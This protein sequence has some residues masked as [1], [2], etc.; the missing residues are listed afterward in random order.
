MELWFNQIETQFALHQIDDDDERYNLTCAALSGEIA[1]DVRDVL[2]QPFRSNKYDS[3]KA[4]LIERR[5]LTTPERVNKVISGEKIGS[6]IPSRFLRRLQKTAG[7]GTKAVVGKAVI[8]QAFIRQMPASIRAHLATQP[9]SA[10]LESLAILADRALAAEEDVEESKPGVAE[11]KVDETS[12]LVGLLEDLSKRIKRLE[13]VTTSE[14]KRNKGRG[15]ANNYAHAPAFVPNVQA[16][17]FI[18]NQHSQYRD[19]KDNARPFVP[20]PN[21]QANEF[22]NRPNSNNCTNAPQNVRPFVPPPQTSQ[23]NVAQPTD[24]A[25]AQVCYYH[26]TY[27]E[28]ARLCSEPC[29]YYVSLGQREVANIALSHSKLLYVADKGHKCRYLIDTGAAVSVLPKSCANGISGA[30]SLPLVAANNSTIKTYGNCKRVVDVGLKREYPWTFIVADVQQPII[31]ADF[32][33]HYNLLVDLRSRCLRDMRTGLAI[34]A[35]LSSIKPLSLNRVDTVQNEYTKLLGQFPELTRP[36]TKGEPVKH[37]ITHKIVTKGHPVFARPRCLAPDKLVTAKREFD[38]MIKL[39]VIE[40]SDSEW[41]SALHMVPKKNGDWRPCGDYCSLNA[42]TVPDRY[43]IPHIQDFTQRLAGSKIFSKIDLVRAYYQ[44]PVEPSDVHKTAVTTPFGLFNFTRT[45]F[46]LRNSGQTFQRFIDHVT[47]RLDFVFVYL[48]D[49]LVTSPDH[50]THKKHLR[51]LF[52]RLSEYGIIIGPEKCQFGTSELSFLGHHVCAEGISPLPSAVDAIVN[53]IKPEKQ[54]ALRRYLGMVNYYHRFIPHCADKLTPLNN[55]LTSANEG[56]TRLSRKSNFDLK[57]NEEAESAFSGSKQIL[58]NATLLVHPDSTAQLNITCDAS[59]VAVG[60]VLQQFLNGMWQPLSFF[61]KKLNPAE[62]RYSEVDRELLA[63]YATIKHFRHN[64]EGRKFFVITDHKPLTFVVSSVTERA[65]L[66]QTRQLAFIAEFTTDIRYV[67]GETNFVADAL[68]RPSVSAIHDGPVIDYKALSLDQ[69]N[70]AEFTRLR[71]STTSTMNFKLLKSFDNQLIWCD[72]STG[73][74]RPY[75]TAK[76]RRKVFS[77][78]HGLGHPSHRATRPLINTRF[79]WHGIN[80]DIARWCRTCKGCQTAKVSRHKTPV[81][82]KFTEPTERFDHVHVY[83]VGPLPYA[84]GFRYLLTCVD[85][86]THWPEAI[87]MVDI[88]AETVAD[89]FFSGWIARYGTPA[90]ITTDRGAQFESKLWDSLCNQFGIIWNRTTS[91]HPQSNGMVERFHH[92]LKAAIM[93]HE[94]PNPWTITLPAVPLGVHSAVKERLGSSAAEMIYGT[95]LRLPGEFTKQYN[96]DAN[97]D[98]ENY[99]R[100]VAMSRLRL[101]PPRDTQQHN[102]FQFKEIATC[103]HV[104]SRRIAIAPPLTAP[105]DGPYKVVARSG[106]DM[107]ILVKG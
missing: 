107:K 22:V 39:G 83:I 93:A 89:A 76:F 27:G 24:T 31:G 90:T 95:T 25:T 21:V 94:S 105:Y 57:W 17:G 14:N 1:S 54:R 52:A 81:F 64:L 68:S 92:Q 103:T 48:D 62:T 75:L 79:V 59:D 55:L 102:I 99:S 38:D 84:D 82:G 29:S 6:D 45:P 97:T 98:L 46:G 51:I 32:F 88:R 91:Y 85:R 15:R 101:C 50:K 30:D 87:P 12:K 2:L 5:G 10:S 104:F 53:F 78:L 20:P 71:H 106:R 60:G 11:I 49:L 18:G 61:S 96:V 40:P 28:K 23:N 35:S 16:S 19:V 7:F 36:T 67:K 34:A 47:C 4:I 100:S 41:S 9:D 66:R 77:N 26:H 8:R 72:V 74:N 65:S 42:Q 44:I 73:H 70:D 86:F 33:I 3:L 80:I 37:G 43:L 58:A 69:A 13:T 63:V 56:H